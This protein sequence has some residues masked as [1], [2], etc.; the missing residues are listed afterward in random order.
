MKER[1]APDDVQ[2]NV[3][4]DLKTVVGKGTR[5]TAIAW[6]KRKEFEDLIWI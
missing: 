1:I 5:S 2:L 3:R 6:R 4:E